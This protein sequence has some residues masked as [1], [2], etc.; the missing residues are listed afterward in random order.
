VD[1]GLS[2][3]DSI[4]SLARAALYQQRALRRRDVDGPFLDDSV[5]ALGLLRGVRPEECS[6]YTVGQ[7]SHS[8]PEALASRIV[9]SLTNSAWSL[10]PTMIDPDQDGTPPP[11]DW[12]RVFA[13]T[14]DQLKVR[15]D[16]AE[17][18]GRWL[19]DQYNVQLQRASLTTI[20]RRDPDLFYESYKFELLGHHAVYASRKNLALMRTLAAMPRLSRPDLADC[21]RLLRH[22]GA[23]KELTML[24]NRLIQGGPLDALAADARQVVHVRAPAA[25]LRPV[26]MFVL[27]SGADL[28]AQGEAYDGLGYVFTSLDEGGP[29]V[30]AGRYQVQS[31]RCESAW[32]AAIALAE[33]AGSTTDVASRLLTA[34]I[35]PL[36]SDDLWD[37]I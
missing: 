24:L 25:T 1:P 8:T 33:V 17:Q 19:S 31:K 30:G 35:E 22:S 32:M 3:E 20:G 34:V 2:G 9:D 5:E 21:I 23:E 37:L 15:S 14:R 12:E 26:D 11:P 29:S 27:R 10:I 16:E 28:L 6:D 13:W 4:S 7:H 36:G 18:Y